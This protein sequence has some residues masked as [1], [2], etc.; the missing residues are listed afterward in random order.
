MIPSGVTHA[1][2]KVL[3][4][5]SGDSLCRR[6]RGETPSCC[7]NP[8]ILRRFCAIWDESTQRVTSKRLDLSIE[9]SHTLALGFASRP[10]HS[11][12]SRPFQ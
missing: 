3:I 5:T 12:F 6:L 10:T 7:H 9:Y 8:A 11:A 2:P 1:I 4:R